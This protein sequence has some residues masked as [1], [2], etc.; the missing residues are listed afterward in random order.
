MASVLAHCKLNFK[1]TQSIHVELQK[2]P[3][4]SILAEKQQTVQANYSSLS[5]STSLDTQDNLQAGLYYSKMKEILARNSSV[6]NISTLYT[7]FNQL[8]NIR[9]VENFKAIML[10]IEKSLQS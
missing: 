6:T 10:L 1:L 5:L 3:F 9:P 4:H 8:Q 2:I 7:F